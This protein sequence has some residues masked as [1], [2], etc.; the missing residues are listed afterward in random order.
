VA[1]PQYDIMGLGPRTP[2]LII[3]PYTRSGDNP[4]GGSVD[5]TVYELSSVLALLA[6]LF[7]LEPM[8][9]RDAEANP[10]LGALDFEN[11]RFKKLVLPLRDDCPYGT[12]FSHFRASWPFLRTIGSPFD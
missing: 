1:P 2:A 8:T 9:D 3:S 4:D 10:L 12:T 5:E 7:G 11:P 6:Q